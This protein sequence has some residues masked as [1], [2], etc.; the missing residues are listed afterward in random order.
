MATRRS[1]DSLAGDGAHLVSDAFASDPLAG[2]GSH[3]ANDTVVA[4]AYYN[5]GIQNNEILGANWKKPSSKK[6]KKTQR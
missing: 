1:E 6:K 5:L 3:L 2:D 4:F